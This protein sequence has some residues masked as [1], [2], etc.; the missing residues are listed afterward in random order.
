MSRFSLTSLLTAAAMA[1]GLLATPVQAADPPKPDPQAVAAVTVGQPQWLEASGERFLGIYTTALTGA[2]L[3]AVII[4]PGLGLTPDWP[5]VIAPLRT[6][7]PGYGW[8]TLSIPLT[9]PTRGADGRWQLEPYFTASRARIQ[10]AVA[11]LQQQGI[12]RVAL[13][14]Q[15]LGAAAAVVN[16][17]GSDALKLSAC[18]AVSLGVPPDSTSSPYQPGLVENIRV[19]LLDIFG[20]RDLDEVTHT[21]A[22]RLAAARRGNHAASRAQEQDPRDHPAAAEQD[23]YIAYRQFQVAGADH[24]FRGAEV[25]LLNRVAG[26]LKNH[27]DAAVA[28]DAK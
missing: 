7:L 21:A 26:W 22:A 27:A 25:T 11:F 19:P 24:R 16:I 5:D 17:S 4:L 18:A 12:T 28:S 15:G 10:A 8:N 2:P 1:A 14:G 20:S 6:G 3:G 9:T 23:A 13:V